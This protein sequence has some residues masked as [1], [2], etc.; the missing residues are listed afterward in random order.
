MGFFKAWFGIGWYCKW[1]ETHFNLLTKCS[2]CSSCFLH[3][4]QFVK[5]QVMLNPSRLLE[6][7]PGIK[8]ETISYTILHMAMDRLNQVRFLGLFYTISFYFRALD[9]LVDFDRPLDWALPILMSDV[10][11]LPIAQL[12]ATIKYINKSYYYLRADENSTRSCINC[13]LKSFFTEIWALLT[14]HLID[15]CAYIVYAY[16]PANWQLLEAFKF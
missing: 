7:Y 14:H 5:I 10:C 16:C 13:I 1:I 4:L 15:P 11:S 8:M 6:C 3:R 9:F 12:I 2:E